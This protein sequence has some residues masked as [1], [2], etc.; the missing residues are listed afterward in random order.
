MISLRARLVL[1]AVGVLAVTLLACGSLVYLT[2]RSAL[3]DRVDAALAARA[4]SISL[5]IVTVVAQPPYFLAESLDK[6]LHIFASPDF[7]LRV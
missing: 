5:S 2:V 1:W 4:Q 3:L 7:A 6:T